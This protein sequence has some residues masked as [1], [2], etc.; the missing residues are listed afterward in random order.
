MKTV[1][2]LALIIGFYLLWCGLTVSKLIEE[3]VLRERPDICL[4]AGH[5]K[6]IS[7]DRV[8]DAFLTACLA[9]KMPISAYNNGRKAIPR[10]TLALSISFGLKLF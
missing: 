4:D 9:R 6:R 3:G 8:D 10:L 2:V 5:M 1:G 7:E